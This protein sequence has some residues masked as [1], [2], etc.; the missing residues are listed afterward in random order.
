M[1]HEQKIQYMRMAAGIVGFNFREQDLDLLVSTYDLILKKK[2]KTTVSDATEV[3]YAV[4]E[5]WREGD[6]NQI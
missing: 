2:G 5:R 4:A 1:T 3:K 6:S